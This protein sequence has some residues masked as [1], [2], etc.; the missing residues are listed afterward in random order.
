MNRNVR[1]NVPDRTAWLAGLLILATSLAPVVRAQNSAMQYPQGS[2][3]GARSM[4]VENQCQNALQDRVS[5]DAGRRVVLQ[6][7]SKSFYPVSA[8]KACAA[9]SGINS[10]RR[11]R[12]QRLTTVWSMFAITG[13]NARPTVRWPTVAETG[14]DRVLAH[15]LV[16]GSGTTRG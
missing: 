4:M 3:M 8:S 12:G 5:A 14:R 1:C 11:D 6:L 13:W 10:A 15:Y 16:Q 9:S 2:E 7:D